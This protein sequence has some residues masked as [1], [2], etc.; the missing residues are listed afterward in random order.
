MKT[1]SKVILLVIGF[2]ALLAFPA[3]TKAQRQ[4]F[5]PPVTAITDTPA[6]KDAIFTQVGNGLQVATICHQSGNTLI[7]F[8]NI[9]Y[10][11]ATLNFVYSDGTIVTGNNG[12]TA[13]VIATGLVLAPTARVGQPSAGNGEFDIDFLNKRIEGQFIFANGFGNTTVSL[14]VWDGTTYCETRATVQFGP[15]PLPP[16]QVR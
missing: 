15:N 7:A 6:A 12:N 11:Y 4:G 10:D 9:G 1:N 14:H 13:K 8:R 2:P 3:T 5:P 16:L